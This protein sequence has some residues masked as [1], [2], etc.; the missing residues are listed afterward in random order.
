MFLFACGS[1]K[2][3]LGDTG[4]YYPVEAVVKAQADSL[5]KTTD[6][7]VK[8]VLDDEGSEEKNIKANEV[9]WKTELALFNDLNPNKKAYAGK[10]RTDTT[11]TE[12]GRNVTYTSG[13]LKLKMLTVCLREDGSLKAIYGDLI[14]SNMFYASSYQLS[15]VPYRAFSINGTQTLKFFNTEKIFSVS[16]VRQMADSPTLTR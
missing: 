2:E 13:D 4:L 14:T 9:E 8:T 6:T 15:L 5:Q 11:L 10:F 7:W 12:D 1:G 16:W 3:D